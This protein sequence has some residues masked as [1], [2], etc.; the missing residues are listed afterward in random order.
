LPFQKEFLIPLRDRAF[1]WDVSLE[2]NIHG[3][4]DGQTI[5]VISEQQDS[6]RL[7]IKAKVSGTKRQIESKESEPAATASDSAKKA[8]NG[9]ANKKKEPTGLSSPTAASAKPNTKAS[10]AASSSIGAAGNGKAQ[11]KSVTPKAASTGAKA[12][13]AARKMMNTVSSPGSDPLDA[14]T[15]RNTLTNSKSLVDKSDFSQIFVKSEF[16][17]GALPFGF[18]SEFETGSGERR[19]S[20]VGF[21]EALNMQFKVDDD[22]PGLHDDAF[23]D[24][25]RPPRKLSWSIDFNAI[26]AAMSGETGFGGGDSSA[27]P[28]G[29]TG[30]YLYEGVSSSDGAANQ[31]FPSLLRASDA[32]GSSSGGYTGSSGLSSSNGSSGAHT[33][34]QN[35]GAPMG[36]TTASSKYLS[37]LS[38]SHGANNSDHGHGM[39]GAGHMNGSS[40]LPSNTNKA[41]ERDQLASM[42]SGAQQSH[43]HGHSSSGMSLSSSAYHSGHSS[44]HSHSGM[45]GS[46]GALLGGDATLSASGVVGGLTLGGLTVPNDGEFR[47]G[48]Y[49]KLERHLK[50]EAFRE[51]KRTRIWRKQIKYDC[52]KRLADTRPRYGR[53]HLLVN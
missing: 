40:M 28:G 36:I 41:S 17:G 15:L 32:T 33:M 42:M 46:S 2:D 37:S 27:G 19:N 48:A 21:D 9:A 29:Y 53:S 51:K 45:N 3:E 23:G 34:G 10:S 22:F 13:A 24:D 25:F 20:V 50:I 47:V 18:G 31:A 14:Q 5:S 49:T 4:N 1:S 12:T 7:V 30:S 16:D 8:K 43:Q 38:V 26:E 52:R 39:S 35:K 44:S 11:A 6:H